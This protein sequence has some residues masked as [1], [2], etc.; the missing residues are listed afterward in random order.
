MELTVERKL[1]INYANDITTTM[2]DAQIILDSVSNSDFIEYTTPA[3]KSGKLLS[4]PEGITAIAPM[5]CR[6]MDIDQLILPSSLRKIGD[7]AFY[8]NNITQIE[9][10]NIDIIGKS[11]FANNHLQ[12]VNINNVKTIDKSAFYQNLIREL[13]IN[14]I[15]NIENYAFASNLLLE[16]NIIANQN[17]MIEKNAFDRQ[18]QIEVTPLEPQKQLS[19]KGVK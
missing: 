2:P 1:K 11:A 12:K 3:G 9:L 10:S 17:L 18:T 19:K 6:N 4:I 14:N 13:E 15:E 5:V 7:G 8:G 16:A